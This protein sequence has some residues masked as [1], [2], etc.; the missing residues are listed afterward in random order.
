MRVRVRTTLWRWLGA[1]AAMLAAVPVPSPAADFIW[2]P[3]VALGDFDDPNSWFATSSAPTVGD[4]VTFEDPARANFAVDGAVDTVTVDQ[5]VGFVFQS[6]SGVRTLTVDDVFLEGSASLLLDEV[7]LALSGSVIG[8]GVEDS[9][10]ELLEEARVTGGVIDG[11]LV[12]LSDASA[13]LDEVELRNTQVNRSQAA[14]PSILDGVSI[15]PSVTLSGN[16]GTTLQLDGTTSLV[17][18]SELTI[19]SNLTAVL[20]GPLTGAG[21]SHLITNFGELRTA[22]LVSPVISFDD[23]PGVSQSLTIDNF[24]GRFEHQLPVEPRCQ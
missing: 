12:L 5:N 2:N 13:V 23:S 6:D 21:D 3:G 11:V 9:K 7:R 1:A 18:D 10:L 17:G 8:M 14:A 4:T 16:S 15:G 19:T 20:N 24:F 22:A